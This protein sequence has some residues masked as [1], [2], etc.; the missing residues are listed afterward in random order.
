MKPDVDIRFGVIKW[1]S[2]EEYTDKALQIRET[3]RSGDERAVLPDLLL[4]EVANALRYNPSFNENDVSEALD[5][6][7]DM[8]MD[9]VTPTSEI[10]NSAIELAFRYDITFYD[11]F[12]VA[13]AKELEITLITADKK[14]HNKVKETHFVEFIGEVS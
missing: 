13:L 11:S 2:E 12:Y 7:L 5:S 3:I 8:G 6:I 14:L 9:I 1:F 10:I 4:Y